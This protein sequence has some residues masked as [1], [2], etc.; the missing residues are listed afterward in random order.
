MA[1]IVK[2]MYVVCRIAWI[3]PLRTLLGHFLNLILAL[4]D[5]QQVAKVIAETAIL[6]SASSWQ[7]YFL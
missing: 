7:K 5:S 1:S 3:I 6:K 2:I 4:D